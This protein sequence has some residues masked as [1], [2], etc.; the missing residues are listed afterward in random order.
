MNKHICIA[1]LSVFATMAH[2][3]P[4]GQTLPPA[5][6]FDGHSNAAVNIPAVGNLPP[7]PPPS[8][9]GYQG[10]AVSAQQNSA[11][12]VD[13]RVV[14]SMGPVATV[15]EYDQSG[16]ATR[17][18]LMRDGGTF[19]FQGQTYKL[20]VKDGAVSLMSGN[21]AARVLDR[22]DS[23]PADTTLTAQ[24]ASAYNAADAV[25]SAGDGVKELT[26][27]TTKFSA[28]SGTSNSMGGSQLAGAQR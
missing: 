28:G 13:L 22:A 11:P 21:K 24:S 12:T 19:T 23:I 14:L 1:L 3:Q 20:S 8:T 15:Q 2:A 4:T 6:P 26:T 25:L 27:G 5:I 7:P 18:T 10:G 9:S 17:T 16:K